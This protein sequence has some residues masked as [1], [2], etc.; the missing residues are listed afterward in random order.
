[1]LTLTVRIGEAVWID[2]VKRVFVHAIKGDSVR[3]GFDFPRNIPVHRDDV[4]QR[5]QAE[6][7]QAAIDGHGL[8]SAR[9]G[10]Q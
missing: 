4:Q 8:E 6:A 3:I 1:M 5:I 9:G 2:G 7:A 10:A